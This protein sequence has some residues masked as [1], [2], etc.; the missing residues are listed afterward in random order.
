MKHR[1]DKKWRKMDKNKLRKDKKEETDKRKKKE[2]KNVEQFIVDIERVPG[3]NLSLEIGWCK[4][5]HGFPQSLPTNVCTVCQ[6][7]V[8]QPP[9]P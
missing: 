3:S 2:G 9:R 4:V 8:R 5:L 7:R 6:V 1:H